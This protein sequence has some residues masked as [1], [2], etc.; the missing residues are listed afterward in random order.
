MINTLTPA[1][2]TLLR[3][4]LCALTRESNQFATFAAQ[5]TQGTAQT[6]SLR[7]IGDRIRHIDTVDFQL[8]EIQAAHVGMP[9][10]QHG[11]TDIRC[12]SAIYPMAHD[13]QAQEANI[14]G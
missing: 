4:A 7:A 2:I 3:S 12:E 14:R 11:N 5:F 1:D 8:R 13:Q 6:K 10:I 9:V